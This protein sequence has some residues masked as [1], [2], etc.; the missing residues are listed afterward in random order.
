MKLKQ[1]YGSLLIIELCLGP[2]QGAAAGE[3]AEREQITQQAQY[4]IA[5]KKYSELEAMADEYRASESKTPA[6]KW[7]L[8]L[9]YEGL[10]NFYAACDVDV[11]AFD[12]GCDDV[13]A[14]WI[15]RYPDSPAAHLAK[16]GL[17]IDR[18]W[19]RRGT[20]YG[21]EVNEEDWQPFFD[22][23]TEARAYLE[24]VKPIAA[25][26]PEWYH[27]M[28]TVAIAQSWPTDKF[29]SLLDEALDRYPLNYSL[30]RS[31]VNYYLPKWHGSAKQVEAFARAAVERT[32]ATEGLG[33]YVRVYWY[34][35]ADQFGDDLFSDSDVVWADMKT[36]IDDVL[37]AYPD[38]W[39]VNSFARFACLAG[40]NQKAHELI[41]RIR[42]DPDPAIWGY[43]PWLFR[44]CHWWADLLGSW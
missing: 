21:S 23:I 22:G 17:L 14:K 24:S 12:T 19:K 11:N 4:L 28:M 3:Q 16:A 42:G 15:E 34:A 39:N 20:G 10:E 37:K 43:D 40:D 7:K 8:S 18:A 44:R 38:Q 35:S 29:A 2:A 30:Y 13:I 26:D 25:K 33:L 41:G 9:F 1:I 31:G 32:R 36:G 5:F 6:G 27:A